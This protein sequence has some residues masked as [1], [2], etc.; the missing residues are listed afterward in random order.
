MY[1]G[2]NRKG[3]DELV[4]LAINAFW[5]PQTITLPKA[6]EGRRF[7]MVID[8]YRE[9]SVVQDVIPVEGPFTIMPRSVAVFETYP[10]IVTSSVH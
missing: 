3:E 10:Y 1:A 5:E 6:P 4:Y 7:Y 9:E 2:R 8:T